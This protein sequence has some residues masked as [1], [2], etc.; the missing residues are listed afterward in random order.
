MENEKFWNCPSWKDLSLEEKKEKEHEETVLKLKE[1]EKIQLFLFDLRTF[2]R[3]CDYWKNT[4]G[5]SL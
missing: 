2:E 4:K 5:K 3:G 1:M